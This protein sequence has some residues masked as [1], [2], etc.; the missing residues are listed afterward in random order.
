[1]RLD[2][3]LKVSRIIKRRPIA[4]IVIDGGKARL[5][6]RVA[7]AGAEVK[8]G[9]VLELEYYDKYFKFEILEVPAGD[10]RKEKAGDLIRVIETR[11]IKVDLLSE[12]E[13]FERKLE[14][15]R[16]YNKDHVKKTE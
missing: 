11:G 2:K 12:E 4:K 6:G 13:I 16:A 1:M 8:V 14:E 5:N 3:F 9:N 15:I 7:K 10:V